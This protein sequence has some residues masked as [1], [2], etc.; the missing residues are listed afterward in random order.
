ML[1]P[2]PSTS[3]QLPTPSRPSTKVVFTLNGETG[4]SVSQYSR[5]WLELVPVVR[6]WLMAGG[7]LARDKARAVPVICGVTPQQVLEGGVQPE[8]Q[9]A[10]SP[11][12]AQFA[13]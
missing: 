8:L 13:V 2:P 7:K 11:A 5:A 4:K 6:S 12:L 10:E 1:A 3:H 9:Q